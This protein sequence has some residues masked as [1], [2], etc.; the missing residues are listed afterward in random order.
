M[1][2]PTLAR[3]PDAVP[4]RGWCVR[5]FVGVPGFDGAVAGRVGVGLVAVH[6]AIGDRIRIRPAARPTAFLYRGNRSRGVLRG[7][8]RIGVSGPGGRLW[9]LGGWPTRWRWP[10]V[11]VLGCGR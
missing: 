1:V 4:S 5:G 7:G 8:A 11:F 10:R 9:W 3:I 6:D 2:S